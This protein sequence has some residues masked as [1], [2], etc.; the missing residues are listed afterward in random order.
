MG[1][2]RNVKISRLPATT[3]INYIVESREI[4]AE[5]VVD[6]DSNVKISRLLAPKCEKCAFASGKR[7]GDALSRPEVLSRPEAMPRLPLVGCAVLDGASA[8]GF[9]RRRSPMSERMPQ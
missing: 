6:S 3:T 4:E 1:W 7:R 5:V 9:T 2:I 8:Q